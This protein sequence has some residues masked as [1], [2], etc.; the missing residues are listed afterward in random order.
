[1]RR[2]RGI[3]LILALIILALMVVLVGQ[4]AYTSKVDLQVARNGRDGQEG[5]YACWGGVEVAKALL[6]DDKQRT[7][8]DGFADRWARLTKPVK[9][10]EIPV[11]LVIEDEERKLNLLLLRSPTEAY[12]KWGR[13]VLERLVVACREGTEDEKEPP[14]STLAESLAT[15]I[16]EGKSPGTL[17]V[18]E[19][20]SPKDGAEAIPPLSLG[21]FLLV[22]GITPLVLWGPPPK[23]RTAE[24]EEKARE[25]ALDPK[26]VLEGLKSEAK[27]EARGLAP[28]LTLWS[29]GRINA[30][31]ADPIV[32]KALSPNMS[33]ETVQAIVSRRA[34]GGGPAGPDEG[35]DS[36]G[37]ATEAAA[38]GVGPKDS[39]FT[40]V[41]QLKDVPG[42]Q[43]LGENQSVYDETK[44]YLAIRSTAFRVTVTAT[45]QRVTR[46]VEVVLRRS[47]G[48]FA[49]LWYKER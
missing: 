1:M 29:N 46:S 20:E 12:K 15:W 3:A 40:S 31:T 48:E 45:V 44:G 6:L 22:K 18:G 41:D 21:E 7:K 39:A 43:N 28:Y 4:L 16:E 38:E 19:D 24:E 42:M 2:S 27:K 17:D 30:N 10:G 14:A 36:S 26:K 25:E 13:G 49:V 23:P 9:V 37:S 8:H 47:A 35:G 34:P 32:L 11:T 5:L 33:D